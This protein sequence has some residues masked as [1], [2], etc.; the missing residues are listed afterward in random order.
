MNWTPKVASPTFTGSIAFQKNGAG[1]AGGSGGAGGVTSSGGTT[2]SGGST[3]SGGTTSSG[4]SGGKGG[5]S[6]TG[7]ATASGGTTSSGGSGGAGGN[8]SSGGSTGGSTTPGTGDR[9]ISMNPP[10]RH[11]WA[12]GGH[13]LRLSR[14]QSGRR[15]RPG[16]HRRRGVQE[17]TIRRSRASFLRLSARHSRRSCAGPA[18]LLAQ[19]AGI[20]VSFH[21]FAIAH[22]GQ[23]S[24]FQTPSQSPGSRSI[25]ESCNSARGLGRDSGRAVG[26]FK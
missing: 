1:G 16:E 10:R 22:P 18:P 24:T 9:A 15:R 6:V 8:T 19:V 12:P 14:R 5:A 4:G 3:S 20:A 23:T 21:A 2:S 25:R 11:V 7:G 26:P 17:V 13:H